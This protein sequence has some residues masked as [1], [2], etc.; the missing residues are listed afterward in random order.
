MTVA[1][2]LLTRI[3]HYN[4]I[5]H[6]NKEKNEIAYKKWLAQFTPAQ[7]K[8]ANAARRLLSTRW[9]EKNNKTKKNIRKFPTIQDDRLVKHPKSAYIYFN[10][11][12]QQSGDFH[13]MTIRESA[14]LI[15]REWKQLDEAS[16]KVCE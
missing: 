15:G 4:H 7:V 1:E 9:A 12:R 10:I 5:A 3:Q 13:K 2:S 8:D 16:R 6:Q 11:D 14:T